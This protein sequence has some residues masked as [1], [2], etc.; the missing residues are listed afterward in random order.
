MLCSQLALEDK[1]V[2]LTSAAECKERESEHMGEYV[3]HDDSVLFL[4]YFDIESVERFE[5]SKSDSA[6][7]YL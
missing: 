6:L 1:F 4:T 2:Q 3:Q 5:E 7:I